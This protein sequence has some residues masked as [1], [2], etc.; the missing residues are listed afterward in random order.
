MLPHD[1]CVY[2]WEMKTDIQSQDTSCFEKQKKEKKKQPKH[3]ATQ[4]W[5]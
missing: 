3:K 1:K 4:D 5:K 2:H